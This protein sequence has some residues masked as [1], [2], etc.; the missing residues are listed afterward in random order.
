[1]WVVRRYAGGST[2][3]VETIAEADDHVE[4]DGVNVLTYW[5][6]QDL[7]NKKAG[8]APARTGPYKVAT[9]SGAIRGTLPRWGK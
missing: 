6:A 5:Q 2:Y 4:A 8:R 1:M 3:I 7:A 9:Q